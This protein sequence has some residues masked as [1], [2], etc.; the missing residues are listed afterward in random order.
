ME[1]ITFELAAATGD[2]LDRTLSLLIKDGNGLV[3]HRAWRI[4]E[5]ARILDVSS[6]IVK[7][8]QAWSS[9]A[10]W[11]DEGMFELLDEVQEDI[12]TPF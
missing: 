10:L 1:S 4:A 9:P 2:P 3:A 8:L 12:A 6:A 11:E 5:S 7:I